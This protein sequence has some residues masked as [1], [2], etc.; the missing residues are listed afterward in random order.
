MAMRWSET[1]RAMVSVDEHDDDFEAFKHWMRLID[2]LLLKRIGLTTKDIA[3]RPYR[4]MHDDNVR[5]FEVVS[6]I[7]SEGLDAL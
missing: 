4:D 6:E 7:L 2:S 5:P 3:D 1:A